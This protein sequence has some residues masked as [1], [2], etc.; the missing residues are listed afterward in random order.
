MF[1]RR[2]TAISRRMF[3]YASRSLGSMIALMLLVVA[4]QTRASADS[5]SQTF[6]LS[7][8]STPQWVAVTPDNSTVFVTNSNQQTVSVF[9]VSGTRSLSSIPSSRALIWGCQTPTLP[10]S[11]S[12][13]TARSFGFASL[14]SIKLP[15]TTC[16]FIPISYIHLPRKRQCGIVSLCR[17][18]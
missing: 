7:A 1:D 17:G 9:S 15:F 16:S 10:E 14:I 6:Q 2:H 13:R 4:S 5:V 12:R 3:F 8:G 18:V 11:E